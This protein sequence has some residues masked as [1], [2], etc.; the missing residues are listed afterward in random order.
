MNCEPEDLIAAAKCYRCIPRGMQ[1]SVQ[2]Y[3]LA[4][5]ANAGVLS[6]RYVLP[7]G[8]GGFWLLVTDGL[9]NLGTESTSGPASS[10]IIL[11][12]ELGGF[13]KVIVDT[14]GLRGAE[15]SAGPATIAPVINHWR[16]VVDS[17]GNVGTVAA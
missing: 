4:S 11:E 1:A 8:A 2:L 15:P 12:D 9:G 6:P 14:N 7:D 17:D 5:I 10:D 13:W 3:L 16:L